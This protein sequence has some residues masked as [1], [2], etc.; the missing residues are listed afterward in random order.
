[1]CSDEPIGKLDL[2]EV[3][4]EALLTLV[5]FKGTAGLP[6]WQLVRDPTDGW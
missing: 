5:V 4:F 3:V 1:M 2:A 6:C